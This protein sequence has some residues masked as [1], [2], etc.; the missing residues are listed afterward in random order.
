MRLGTQSTAL[1]AGNISY[2]NS[3]CIVYVEQD[4]QSTYNV[5]LRRV[6]LTIV[7]VEKK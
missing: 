7:Y 6:R 5:T 2:S 3:V 4:R 1:E